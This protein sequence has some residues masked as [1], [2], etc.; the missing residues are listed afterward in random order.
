MGGGPS[1]G[2]CRDRGCS[3]RGPSPQPDI[4][5]PQPTGL[6]RPPWPPQDEEINLS[7]RGRPSPSFESPSLLLKL[8]VPSSP[9]GNLGTGTRGRKGGGPSC[10]VLVSVAKQPGLPELAS[11]LLLLQQRIPD[12]GHQE[13]GSEAGGRLGQST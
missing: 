9:V 3:V 11:V 1:P 7:A 13:E 2:N 4:S 12:P 10:V 6:S 8:L 5:L